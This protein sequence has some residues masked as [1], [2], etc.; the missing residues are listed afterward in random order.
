MLAM[1]R[2][3]GPSSKILPMALV[4][5]ATA[6][7]SQTIVHAYCVTPN[8]MAMFWGGE[9]ADFRVPVRVSKGPNTSVMH[10]GVSPED[11]ARILVE[12]IARHNES[13]AVPK[14]YF[15]GIRDDDTLEPGITIRS[16]P[17]KEADEKNPP[18]NGG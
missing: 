13:I 8:D 12:V 15:A 18:C 4:A 9:F 14:L 2:P 11:L 10:A 6:L 5:A 16:L 7:S 1:K 17:C 3:H